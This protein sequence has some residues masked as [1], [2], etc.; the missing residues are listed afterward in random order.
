M[1]KSYSSYSPQHL[2][3]NKNIIP[4]DIQILAC[5]IPSLFATLIPLSIL[6]KK[7]FDVIAEKR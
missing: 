4:F 5:N 7:K 1:E 6:Y 2:M 3:L